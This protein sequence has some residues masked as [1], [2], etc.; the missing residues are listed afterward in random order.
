M[1]ETVNICLS[2]QDLVIYLEIFFQI[3]DLGFECDSQSKEGQL[4]L[5]TDEIVYECSLKQ[6]Y[7]FMLEE[8]ILL[9]VWFFIFFFSLNMTS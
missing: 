7:S 9:Q 3:F 5:S 2:Y 4:L 6:I 8:P 1:N